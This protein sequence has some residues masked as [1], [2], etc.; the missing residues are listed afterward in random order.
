M[1]RRHPPIRS[2]RRWLLSGAAVLLVAGLLT[3]I[4]SSPAMAGPVNAVTGTAT[5]ARVPIGVAAAV[6]PANAGR[7][8]VANAA[9]TGCPRNYFCFWNQAGYTGRMGKLQDCGLQDLATWSWQYQV[10]SAYYNLD[11]GS[12]EFRYGPSYGLFRVGTASRGL[13]D[14]GAYAGWATHVYRYCYQ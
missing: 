5:A 9:P 14:A 11:S 2:R 10:V 4:S 13:P 8:D 1:Q 7:A 6:V 3:A 12:V